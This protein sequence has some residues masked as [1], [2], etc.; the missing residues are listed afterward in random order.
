MAKDVS[1]GWGKG[2]ILPVPGWSRSPPK[3]GFTLPQSGV[4]TRL[5][6]QLSPPLP[7]MHPILVWPKARGAPSPAAASDSF[8]GQL[9]MEQTLGLRRPAAWT[10]LEASAGPTHLCHQW[11]Y[12]PWIC[13]IALS[14]PF[15]RYNAPWP[16]SP[17]GTKLLGSRVLALDRACP[18]TAGHGHSH[19]QSDPTR[20]ATDPR[21]P[22][23][24]VRSLGRTPGWQRQG[25]RC[26]P[27]HAGV[28]GCRQGT[29]PG[30]GDGAHPPCEWSKAGA[31]HR[32]Q[33]RALGA[34][35]PRDFPRASAARVR[36]SHAQ[37]GRRTR[38]LAMGTQRV[39]AR[40]LPA[41]VLDPAKQ[42]VE[43]LRAGATPNTI[44]EARAA[45]G[46]SWEPPPSFGA[47]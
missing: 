32:G 34:P 14:N 2:R 9:W 17:H 20:N 45:R 16:Q 33:L 24:R 47:S 25:T 26:L 46:A 4:S 1:E 21:T 7:P 27:S 42:Q 39:P 8:V 23:P 22:C 29:C 12:P 15:F 28:R 41:L 18:A 5:G 44:P 11:V 3:Q 13:L 38:A 43:I 37:C 19:A 31:G 35:H 36:R 30:Q 6:P 40:G 10:P